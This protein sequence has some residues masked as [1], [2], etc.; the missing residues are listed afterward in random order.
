M[1]RDSLV[2]LGVCLIALGGCQPELSTSAAIS[3][4]GGTKGLTAWD[5]QGVSELTYVASEQ[6]ADIKFSSTF[7]D[8]AAFVATTRAAYGGRHGRVSASGTATAP[9]T[10]EGNSLRAEGVDLINAM[11]LDASPAGLHRYLVS[12]GRVL[13]RSEELTDGGGTEL[14]FS[15]SGKEVGRLKRGGRRNASLRA[16]SGVPTKV[17]G[18]DC[19]VDNPPEDCVDPSQEVA[20]GLALAADAQ[21]ATDA[22][23]S[24]YANASA[25]ARNAC[26][27]AYN[28]VFVTGAIF[29]GTA[30]AAEIS[31]DVGAF[32]VTWKLARMLPAQG[33]GFWL[34]AGNLQDCLQANGPG[35]PA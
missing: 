18:F 1:K 14:V 29:F 17:I 31:A 35:R 9:R 20:D 7:V 33:I 23:V 22:M 21:L 32:P 16:W 27:G 2:F 12:H 11:R 28:A 13:K 26:Q 34:A 19:E 8:S 10:L 25:P 30:A 5:Q 4:V 24:L 3:S 6:H 15:L